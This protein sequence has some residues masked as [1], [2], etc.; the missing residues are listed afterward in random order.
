MQI[1]NKLQ[2]EKNKNSE[3]V[4]KVMGSLKNKISACEIILK[5]LEIFKSGG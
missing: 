1:S 4:V 3:C 5:N 2:D